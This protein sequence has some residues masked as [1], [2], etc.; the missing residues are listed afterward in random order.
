MTEELRRVLWPKGH[1]PN[2]WAIVDAAQDQ[3]VYWTL[4]NSFLP[5]SCLFAGTLPQALEMAAPYLVQL[6]PE[7]KFTTYLAENLNRNL[8]IFLYSDVSLRELRHH[9]RK[10]LTVKDPSG[11]KMMFRYYDPRIM[12][13]YLPTCSH[14]ELQTVFGPIR[15]I[16]TVAEGKKGIKQFEIKNKQLEVTPFPLGTVGA[17]EGLAEIV[18]AQKTIL[19]GKGTDKRQRIPILLQGAGRGGTLRRSSQ[20]LRIY[21][22]IAAADELAFPPGGYAIPVSQ[23][24]PDATVYAEAAAPGDV[25]LYLETTAGARAEKKVTAV[26]LTLNA[27]A[28]HV[29]LGVDGPRRRIEVHPPKP[30][31]FSGRLILRASGGPAVKLYTEPDAASGYSLAEGYSFDSPI[32]PV[33]FWIDAVAPS[34]TPGD[35][36]LQLSV[37]GGNSIGDACPATAVTYGPVQATVPITPSPSG[38]GAGETSAQ[39]EKNPLVLL[40]GSNGPV[41]LRT[42]VKPAGLKLAWTVTRH[43]DDTEVVKK[44]SANALPALQTTESGATLSPNSAGSFTVRATA[45]S[46]DGWGGPAA[47]L[48]LILVHAALTENSCAVNGRFCACARVPGSDEFRLHSGTEAAITLDAAVTLTGGGP[49]A[50]RGVDSIQGGWINNI[51]A[52]NSGAKYK[53]GGSVLDT[54]RLP[55]AT[56]ADLDA[57]PLLDAPLSPGANDPRCMSSNNVTSGNGLIRF[58]ASASPASSWKVQLG[59]ASDKPI[60]QIWRYLECR[61]VLA[62]WSANAPGQVGLLM[63][64]GWSFTGD[65]ACTPLKTIRAVVPVRLAATGSSTFPELVPA[66]GTGIELHPPVSG[67]G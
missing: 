25:T 31:S 47:E 35:I 48:E 17:D 65:F 63:Q 3:Q 15:T 43:D 56:E 13:V 29:Y 64:L 14:T 62:L 51:I 19:I 36:Q 22:T 9:L 23:L 26:E 55:N 12:R 1:T 24:E 58:R 49:D 8:C 53:G 54:Y 40:T 34:T 45:Q 37:E 61:S 59:G 6:D 60:E 11:K 16:W 41:E 46:L 28:D 21:R 38:R 32:D 10:F 4:T 2:V 50:R 18:P 20:G 57:G 52:D 30:S 66:A 39:V 42:E 44:L 5:H 67:R 27:G 33:Q 7:D